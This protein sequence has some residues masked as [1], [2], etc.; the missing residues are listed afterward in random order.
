MELL[1]AA[2]LVVV[3]A[4]LVEGRLRP[5]F[6]PGRASAVFLPGLSVL[7]LVE[8]WVVAVDQ[9]AAVVVVDWEAAA[10]LVDAPGSVPGLGLEPE[11]GLGLAV[12][13]V[14]VL[15]PAS[16]GFA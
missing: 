11:L 15:E 13:H 5:G 6:G 3:A 16:V 1:A 8:D 12:G 4:G 14:R 10:L 2:G 7:A 9:P